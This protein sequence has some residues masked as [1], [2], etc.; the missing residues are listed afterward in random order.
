MRLKTITILLLAVLPAL[1]QPTVVRL[2]LERAVM[3]ATDSSLTADRHRSVFQEARYAWLSWQAGRHL[4]VELKTIPLQFEQDMV[5]RYVSDDDLDE[6]RQQ[7]RLLSSADLTAEQIM[8]KWG[9][10]FYARTG[11]AYLG[12]Y[13]ETNQHQFATIP[14]S[15]GYKQDLL[16]FNPYRWSRQTEP[17]RLTVAEQQMNYDVERTAEEAVARFFLLAMA[18]EQLQ[19]ARE[20]L[21]SCD[22][23]YA[24]ASRRFRIA[25]IS[26]AELAILELQLAN[27]RNA[28]KSAQLDHQK[29]VR[30]LAVWLGMDEGIRLELVVP[31]LL[32]SLSV[33]LDDAIAQAS[34]N[35][36]NYLSM[37]LRE[38]EA[39]RDAEQLKRK[40]GLNASINAS[41]GLNQV[42]D[43]FEHA[44]RKP[45][46]QNQVIVS[47]TVPIADH[48]K[49][50]NAW[51]AA[52]RKAEAASLQSS[53]TRRDTEFDVTQTVAEVNERQTLAEDVRRAL[54]IAEDAYTAMLQRFIRGQANVNDLSLAQTHWQ[55]ARKN[56]M[57]ALQDFWK[58]YYHLRTL[59][60]YDYLKHMPIRHH[61]QRQRQ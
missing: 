36:P 56:Q 48:G 50:R 29:A 37:Q 41:M 17:M 20:H 2:D 25:S 59:T 9:G 4:Q 3:L 42:A 60:L 52:E 43:R 5:Q 14:V 7:K 10:S 33:S 45:L 38:L 32:P 40:K 57:A 18:Q 13:G 31:S 27:A 39:R 35:N 6:Y 12:N 23:I 61:A 34:H 16:G 22:T 46:V 19:M 49:K 30:S 15:V 8:E 28:L 1:A 55:S 21:Q 11:I 58:S 44:F 24:I 53:E 47:L 26:K 54:H 51:L